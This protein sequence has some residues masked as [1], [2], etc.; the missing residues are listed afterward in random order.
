MN[1]FNPIC[2]FF[3]FNYCCYAQNLFKT[4]E[5]E[6]YFN[7]STLLED[8]KA[9]HNNVKAINKGNYLAVA[10]LVEG[11]QFKNKLM[12]EHFNENYIE[13]ERYPKAY[14]SGHIINYSSDSLSLKAK[15]YAI[16]GNLTL[17][18]I[19]VFIETTTDIK[20]VD[21]FIILE[22]DFNINPE[23][24]KIKIPKILFNKVAQ[25]VNVDLYL[26]LEKK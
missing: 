2:F 3:I 5:G 12:Q 15:E 25:E 13:S 4:D 8:I 7:G 9:K 6:V 21:N 23:D 22:S 14:F 17:H 1:L 24:F 18:G 26:K 10:L 16:K 19:T 11:F 20:I